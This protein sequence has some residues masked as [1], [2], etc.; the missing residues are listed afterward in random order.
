MYYILPKHMGCFHI[1][2]VDLVVKNSSNRLHENRVL[3]PNDEN[4]IVLTANIW[5]P[6]KLLIVKKLAYYN[7]MITII[8][9]LY[10][11]LSNSFKA[12][13]NDLKI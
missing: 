7:N 4:F 12:L 3:F 13:D 9:Y 11:T 5:L 1:S 2:H 8:K 10:S 6:C